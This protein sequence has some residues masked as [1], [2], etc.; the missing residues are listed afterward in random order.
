M[1]ILDKAGTV[2][3]PGYS[4]WLIPPAA[5]CVHLSIGQ[6]YS[7]SVFKTALMSHFEASYVQVGWIFSVAILMLGASSAV[8]GTW[9]E[10]N[11]P[12][13]AMLVSCCCWVSGFVIAAIGVQTGQLWLVYLGYGGIGGIGLGIGYISPVSTLMKWFPE[14]PGLATGIAIMGFG[15]GALFGAPLA[16][17]LLSAYDPGFDS[18]V[19]GAAPGG[20]AVAATFLT[21]GGIY[22]VM[23]LVGAALIRIPPGFESD[24]TADHLPARNGAL[25]RTRQA[26]RTPAFYLLWVVLFCN[27]TA[28]IG[29]L[30]EASPMI[31]DLFRAPDGRTAI[32]AGMATGFVGLLSLANMGGR[33]GWSSFSDKIGRRWAYVVYLGVGLAMYLALA[34]GGAAVALF[35]GFMIITFY[36]GGFATIPAYLKDMFG[37][38]EVGAIHGRL[39]TAWSAAGICGPLI[40]NSV[41]D[42][43]GGEPGTLT[44]E[45][46]S[47]AFLVMVGILAVGFTANLLVRG[48]TRRHWDEAQ[49]A[50]YEQRLAED[51][52]LANATWNG[53]H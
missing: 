14:R 29:I 4:R 41:L 23:M 25:V 1:G 3:R 10:H 9:M 53:G 38:L 15:G 44:A 12:R 47:P 19:L 48:V 28:G 37:T 35:V 18:S 5:L 50:R 8:F 30:E 31:Q 36:G 40:V 52:S 32:T 20:H 22:L 46:Y 43:A 2:A 21:L 13:K 49:V 26:V 16:T 42:H 24:E 27:V 33:I 34:A 45:A 51:P 17:A 7:L 39:L 11:G 6:V